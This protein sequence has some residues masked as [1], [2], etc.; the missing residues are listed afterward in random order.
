MNDDHQIPLKYINQ[1]KFHGIV[2]QGL[3]FAS[4]L[5]AMLYR[6]VRI[7]ALTLMMDCDDE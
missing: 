3:Q 5:A 4:Y 1:C 6:N 2:Q 7:D